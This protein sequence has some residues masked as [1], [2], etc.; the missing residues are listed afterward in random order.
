M[1]VSVFYCDPEDF[2]PGESGHYGRLERKH[3]GKCR[4][5]ICLIDYATGSDYSGGSVERSNYLVMLGDP[6][7]RPHVIDIHGG[8]G[9]Y[10][11]GYIAPDQDHPEDI[12][13]EGFPEALRDAI[14][15]LARY[16]LLDE[17]AHSEREMELETEAWESDG[18]KDF[19]RALSK[20]FDGMT[21]ISEDVEYEHDLDV[22]P[23]EEIDTLWRD[24]CDA[25]NV[26]GGT[27]F[28]VETGELV[29]FYIKEWIRGY[30]RGS[31][32]ASG[33]GVQARVDAMEERTRLHTELPEGSEESTN[34]H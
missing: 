33:A 30:E 2:I 15:S 26:N 9:T 21:W 12:R 18:R 28:V 16:P 34:A 32:F 13:V 4:T 6:E 19:R 5:R 17:D 25:F 1:T 10:A 31:I 20:H 11:I 14:A 24:G 23:D 3:Y 22:V 8:H 7:I 27:G 29:H